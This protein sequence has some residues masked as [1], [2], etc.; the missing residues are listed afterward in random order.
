M[1]KPDKLAAGPAT[2]TGPNTT[3]RS[4]SRNSFF[5]FKLKARVNRWRMRSNN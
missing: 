4:T 1:G 5:P 3:E 2:V